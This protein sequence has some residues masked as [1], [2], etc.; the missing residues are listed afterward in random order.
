MLEH[1]IEHGD[2]QNLPCSHV[3]L[4]ALLLMGAQHVGPCC[5][6]TGLLCMLVSKLVVCDC[7]AFE[8]VPRKGKDFDPAASGG[9]DLLEEMS[10]LELRHRLAYTK[11]RHLV[12]LTC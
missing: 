6:Q 10:L 3:C 5:L 8:K 4:L 1:A 7:R 11:Q 9:H 12:H 2:K